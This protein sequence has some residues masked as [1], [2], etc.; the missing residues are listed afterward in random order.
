MWLSNHKIKSSKHLLRAFILK[1]LCIG[2][3][4]QY[5]AQTKTSFKSFS[6]IKTSGANVYNFKNNIFFSF[7]GATALDG[8]KDNTMISLFNTN[9]D[10][11]TTNKLHALNNT[12]GDN[13]GII[14]ISNSKK[15][16]FYWGQYYSGSVSFFFGKANQNNFNLTTQRYYRSISYHRGDLITAFINDT[17]IITSHWMQPG[18]CCVPNS[19]IPYQT[20]VWWLNK[21]FD[22]IQQKVYSNP[23]S[24][25]LGKTIIPL[26]NKDILVSGFVDTFD[27]WTA[28]NLDVFLLRLDSVGN[29]KFGRRIGTSGSDGMFLKQIGSK[30]YYIG[31]SS[32][33][34]TSSISVLYVA[35]VDINNGNIGKAYKAEY[36]GYGLNSIEPS[37]QQSKIYMP[38]LR[39]G[40]GSTNN[41]SCYFLLDTNG[42]ISKQ[43]LHSQASNG[44]LNSYTLPIVTDSLK[45]VYGSIMRYNTNSD[46][47]YTVLFKL[48]SNLVGCYPSD[49]PYSF[50]TTVATA[51]F[52]SLPMPFT[53]TRDSLYEVFGSIVQGHGFNTIVDE[54]SGFVGIKE[55]SIGNDVFKLY[56]NPANESLTL[57]LSEGE[58]TELSLTDVLGKE[59]NKYKMT[60]D[61]I[62]ISLSEFNV[63]VYFIEVKT[64]NGVVRK[65]FVKE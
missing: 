48:D 37:I 63:G 12:A 53:V 25:V 55:Q 5:N 16:L 14:P 29:V 34:I 56:P 15:E 19:N 60:S 44:Y 36:N 27:V 39:I 58:G 61:S 32:T 9:F 13:F 2:F 31:S 38:C 43:Y 41:K 26:A 8:N 51:D 52:H 40:Y 21:N 23:I 22:T 30:Y 28:K 54:C 65:K 3:C 50:T 35:E 33:T 62:T 6:D 17:V 10:T 7:N 18:N 1:T 42:I 46:P 64:S 57:T 11:L 4:F 59:L 49:T 47:K 24:R 45:N 20:S